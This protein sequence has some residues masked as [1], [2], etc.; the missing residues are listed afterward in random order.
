MSL[1]KHIIF[2]FAVKFITTSEGKCTYIGYRGRNASEEVCT[3]SIFCSKSFRIAHVEFP[4]Y[5][6]S[7]VFEKV[8]EHCCG[9]CTNITHTNTYRNISEVKLS[10]HPN[11]T[12]FILPF[13]GKSS[14]VDLYG[15][16]FI[17]FM[18]CPSAYYITLKHPAVTARIIDKCSSLYTVIVMCILVAVI[19]GFIVWILEMIYAKR[20][21]RLPSFASGLFEGFWWSF[22]TI[23]SGYG[24]KI[25]KSIPAKLYSVLWIFFGVVMFSLLTSMFTAELMNAMNPHHDSMSGRRVGVLKYRDYDASLVVRE[26]GIIKETNSW[27]FYSDVLSLIRMLRDGEVDGFVIDKYTLTYTKGY[28]QWKK[29]NNDTLVTMDKTRGDKYEERKE[30]IY[31]FETGLSSTLD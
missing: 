23:T 16:H 18:D 28:L 10:S 15:Y 25:V 13:L 4:P 21:S 20:R 8:V 12:D 9:P 5:S 1:L 11:E 14:A 29:T 19:S 22:T 27:N 24:A 3:K 31:F 30:D 2:F 26:G 17:P 6:T 7:K